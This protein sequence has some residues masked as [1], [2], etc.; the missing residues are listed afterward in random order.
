M[1]KVSIVILNYN[2]EGFLRKFLPSVIEYSP[3]HEIVV[4]DSASTDQSVELLKKH[5][6]AVKIIEL[7]E[8][9]GFCG[10][11]NRALKQLESEYFIIINSDVEVTK[12]WIDPMLALFDIDASIAAIQPKLL[13]FKQK[14][15]FEYAGGAG[16]FIDKFGYPFCR[17]RL[18]DTIENDTGQYDDNS[19]IFWAT[20]ACFMIRASL[21]KQY[22]GFDE[23]F[24]AH[25]EEIDLCWRMKMDGFKIFY[26]G[27]S[28]VYHVGGGTLNYVN[29]RKTFLNFRNS[30]LVLIK[31][32]PMEELIWKLPFRWLM[33]YIAF[34]KFT[35]TGDFKDGF[36][37]FKAHWYVV[38]NFRRTF[39]KR[40]KKDQTTFNS[41]G[42][43][44]KFLLFD[45][46]VA[47][48][49]NFKDLK[50]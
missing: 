14:E 15:R 23:S 18:F 39:T 47:G 37:I 11:Y 42:I 12:N 4:A 26:C 19:E 27:E 43:Y 29:P 41:A 49:R 13:D 20:G 40:P 34:L 6:S 2:G 28:V 46:H 10:G 38:F 5:F 9:Y 30:L 17:G 8:N 36:M 50:S 45:Y 24:F 35:L 25:M 31:N 44:P 3:G 32:L 48:V 21:F 33:D 16:G 22:G 7:E 1:A